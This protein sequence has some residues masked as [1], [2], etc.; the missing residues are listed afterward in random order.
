MWA[1]YPDGDKNES[2]VENDS[3]NTW[4]RLNMQQ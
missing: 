3:L 4:R 2:D 1:L